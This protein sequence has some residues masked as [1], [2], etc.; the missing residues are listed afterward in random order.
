MNVTACRHVPDC[1]GAEAARFRS[2]DGTCNNLAR[3]VSWGSTGEVFSRLVKRSRR[4]RTSACIAYLGEVCFIL[5]LSPDP[6]VVVGYP[7]QFYVGNTGRKLPN[8]RAVSNAIH[9]GTDTI[10]SR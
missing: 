8:A 6:L 2:I 1:S 4:L 7:P 5:I 10:S 3:D 9:S